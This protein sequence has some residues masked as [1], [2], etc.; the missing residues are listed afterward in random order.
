MEGSI[1][2]PL[3]LDGKDLAITRDYSQIVRQQIVSTLQT[4]QDELLWYPDYGIPEVVFNAD[5]ISLIVAVEQALEL[6]L[7]NYPQVKC[8]VLADPRSEGTIYLEVVYTINDI[9]DT[10]SVTYGNT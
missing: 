9:V 10:V 5:L 8:E 4:K 2:Y 7:A 1:L 6:A 3:E